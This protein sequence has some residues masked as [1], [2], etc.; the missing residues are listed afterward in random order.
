[1][2]II[3]HYG[4]TKITRLIVGC[5]ESAVNLADWMENNLPGSVTLETVA[6][7]YAESI[8][9]LRSPSEQLR[10]GRILNDYFEATE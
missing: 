1:M 9:N 8:N 3:Y 6:R 7:G 5:T 4:F 10:A 2:H